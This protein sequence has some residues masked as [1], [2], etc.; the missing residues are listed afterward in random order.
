MKKGSPEGYR[1]LAG[2]TRGGHPDHALAELVKVRA[3]CINHCAYCVQL[4]E[5]AA[6]KAGISDERLTALRDWELSGLFDGRERV[7]L[8]LTDLLTRTDALSHAEEPASDPTWRAAAAAFP[9][10]ELAQLVM[11]ITAINAWNRVM[12]A[13]GLEPGAGT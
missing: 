5:E 7:A 13:W 12:I 11:T 1:A 4:H 9:G 8:A 3:S 6:R 2:L 10:E